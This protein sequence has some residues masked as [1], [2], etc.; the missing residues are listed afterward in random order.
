MYPS[1]IIFSIAAFVVITFTFNSASAQ[2]TPPQLSSEDVT[3][4]LQPYALEGE[5]PNF[6]N[7]PDFGYA[8][9]AYTLNESLHEIISRVYKSYRPDY[10]GFV[11]INPDTGKVLALTSYTRSSLDLQNIALGSNYPA[12]SIFKV[13]TAAAALDKNKMSV[14]TVV[15]FNGKSTTLYKRQTL[16]HKD[17]KYTRRPT[18]KE[19][20]A[21]STNPVFGRVGV[22]QLGKSGMMEYVDKFDF[23][24]RIS[25]DLPVSES[26]F[27]LPLDEEWELAEAGSGY[28]RDIRIGPL[29]AASMMATIMNKGERVSPYVVENI[30][31]AK[32]TKMYESKVSKLS[33]EQVIKEKTADDVMRM[34][35]ETVRIGS[36]RK[37]FNRAHRYKAY[38]DLRYGGKTGSLS[39]DA[40]KGR[41]DWFVGFAEKGDERI[42]YASLIINKEKWYVKS[43]RVAF[44]VLNGYYKGL[45]KAKA[46]AAALA[47]QTNTVD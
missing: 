35:Q 43:S 4:L 7:V 40:P 17:N 39:G 16:S 38:R 19:A 41:Y 12:A 23:G 11:A 10:A 30:M 21:K 18:F 44:E 32:S 20:F 3:A 46:D 47:A 36:A 33:S 29:H 34:M 9:V 14:D 26:R 27:L 42:A 24:R 13:I 22:R 6:L 15:P 31:D 45:A 1:K 5:F 25:V 37:S 8:K 28:T 2:Q